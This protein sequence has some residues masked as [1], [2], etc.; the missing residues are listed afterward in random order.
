MDRFVRL[1][2]GLPRDDL[3]AA[4]ERIAELVDE[5]S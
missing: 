5:L 4:L 1:S 3:L 2:F